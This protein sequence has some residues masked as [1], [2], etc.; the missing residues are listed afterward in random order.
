MGIETV[1]FWAVTSYSLGGG[2][3]GNIQS[4]V[5]RFEVQMSRN[6]ISYIQVYSLQGRLSCDPRRGVKE[7]LSLGY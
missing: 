4:P 3:W 5:F 1:D 2:Y 7:E 6:Y